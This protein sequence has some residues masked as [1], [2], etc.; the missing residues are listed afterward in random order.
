MAFTLAK[1]DEC[2]ALGIGVDGSYDAGAFWRLAIACMVPRLHLRENLSLALTALLVGSVSPR[3]HHTRFRA[4]LLNTY[5]N[6]CGISHGPPMR[7]KPFFIDR[8]LDKD[9]NNYTCQSGATPVQRLYG[10]D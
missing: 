5:R 6:G 10:S 1:P 9:G 7:D 3:F 2:I 4:P 8:A